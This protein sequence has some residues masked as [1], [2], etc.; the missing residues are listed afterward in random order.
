MDPRFDDLVGKPWTEIFQ[1]VFFPDRVYHAQYL[2]AT[3]SSRYRYNIHEVRGKADI[4]VL[5]G[6]VLLDG[7]VLSNV[8]RIEY[9]ASRLVET[10]REKHRLLG[11]EVIANIELELPTGGTTTASH[12]MQYCPW[13][14]AYQLELWQTLEPAAGKRHD[15]QVLDLMGHGGSIVREPAFAP[16]LADCRILER[17][18]L[19]FRETDVT[20]PSGFS[21]SDNQATWDNYFERNVQTPN[22]Q[23]PNSANNTV[24]EKNYR[25]DFQRGWFVENVRAIA[26]VRYENGM[27]DADNAHARPGNIIE[28]RWVLQQEFGGTVVFFHEV[29]IPPGA[30]EGTHQHIGSE[31]LY[32]V[33]EG[34]GIAYFGEQDD[35][36][37]QNRPLV[38]RDVY[39]V[40]KKLCR[41]VDVVPGSVI[42]TKSGGI[43]GIENNGTQPLRFV[44]FLH[45]T[46]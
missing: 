3:R 43:H 22:T 37:L 15:F 31:E 44:A 23:A 9:R 18:R 38:E 33:T 5:K 16:A 7:L 28:M 24:T 11:R 6:E 42:F 14:G 45:H 40:G 8:L 20:W 17:V 35:P 27:M 32:Y 30:V 2:N 21:L 34:H 12:R 41:Q 4:L 19:W 29:T 36:T 25:V 1:V 39:G 10:A 26:P 13:I 46:S